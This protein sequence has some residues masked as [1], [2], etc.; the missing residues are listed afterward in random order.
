PGPAPTAARTCSPR[1]SNRAERIEGAILM[2]IGSAKWTAP[3]KDSFAA[4]CPATARSSTAG[5]GDVVRA[6]DEVEAHAIGEEVELH[7]VLHGAAVP[8]LGRM[9]RLHGHL[10]SEA[11][12]R[13]RWSRHDPRATGQGL[14]PDHAARAHGGAQRRVP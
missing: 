6:Q 11:E 10:V 4:L 13:I 1:R 7:D 5:S 12:R 8:C 14:G 3:N 9:Q 2:A